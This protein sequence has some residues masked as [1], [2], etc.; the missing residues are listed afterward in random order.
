MIELPLAQIHRQI[1]H[2]SAH[3]FEHV[4][5]VSRSQFRKTVIPINPS[6]SSFARDFGQVGDVAFFVADDGQNGRE[7]WSTDGTA[8]SLVLDINPGLAS[9][10]PQEQRSH[11]SKTS[12]PRGQ[13]LTRS[14][15]LK[16]AH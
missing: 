8:A 2:V 9:S 3:D 10:D 1:G 4:R 11:P 6:G 14:S 16:P 15:I 12:P 5:A 7:L 13:P